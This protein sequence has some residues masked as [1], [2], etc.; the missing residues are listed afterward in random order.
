MVREHP[1]QRRGAVTN[2]DFTDDEADEESDEEVHVGDKVGKKPPPNKFDSDGDSGDD[3]SDD[4][5][6]DSDESNLANG[7]DLDEGLPAAGGQGKVYG[8]ISC[9]RQATQL[10]NHVFFFSERQEEELDS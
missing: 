7:E 8:E 2:E 1:L 10:A 9:I 3:S 6:D 5:S 4:D